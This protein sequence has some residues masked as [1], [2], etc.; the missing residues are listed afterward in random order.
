MNRPFYCKCRG[1]D[2]AKRFG[3]KRPLLCPKCGHHPTSYTE[4]SE[5]FTTF[6]ANDNGA[7]ETEGNHHHGLITG[8]TANCACGNRWRLRGITQITDVPG[9]DAAGRGAP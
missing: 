4:A 2:E 9:Y 7:P 5:A 8:V 6:Q 3:T 1:C